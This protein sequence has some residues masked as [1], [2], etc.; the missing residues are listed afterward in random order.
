MTSRITVG[1]DVGGTFTDVFWFNA[2]ARAF[3]TCKVPSRRGDEAQGFLDG[4]QA[5]GGP[6]GIG[7][8]VHGTTVGTNTL[9]E[10]R[11]PKIGVI[12]TR[13][14][15]DVLEMRRRDRR[16]TW[17]LWGD[18][19]PIAARDMR[20]EVNERTLA[21][22]TIRTP[23]D[24]DGVRAAARQLLDQGAASL[25]IT[26]INAYANPE[27]EQRALE[28]VR[29]LWPNEHVG[30][31]HEV[32]AEIREFERSSTTALNAYLQP[33][34]GAYLGKL[35]EP[36]AQR[37]FKGQL[38]IVQSNGGIMAT[39]TARRL[40][41]RTALS[42]PAAGV[43]AGAALA[44]AAGFDNVITC[45]LGGTSFDVSVIAAGR[46]SIAA[47]STIDFGL[48]IRT[49]M[50][51][52]TTIGA[53]GGSIASV[54]PAGLLRV[55]PESAGS[56]PGPACY[57]QGNALPTL[58]DAQ[59]VLGRI[60]AARPLGGE[61]KSLDVDAASAAIAAQVG[62][63]LR[64]DVAD[65]A[66]AIVQVAE[67]RMAG[68]IRLVSIERGHDPTR[69]VAMAFGGGG[70]LHVGAL[71]R[72]VGLRGAVV[73]RFP[74]ITSA[75]G[76]VLADLRHDLVQTVNLDLA[77]LD[78]PALQA[79]LRE[80]G[81]AAS[82]VVA[83]AGMAI[84][85]I[86][87]LHELDMHYVGQTHTIAVPLNDAAEAGPISVTENRV[88]A[89][90]ETAYAASFSRLLHGIPVRVASLRVAAIGRR[91]PFDCAVF[92]PDADAS[93]ARA[94]QPSRAVWFP[95]GW[96]DTD[97]WSRLDL[98]AGAVIA[99]P[100]ILEQPDATTVIEPGLTG[101]VDALG[102]VLVASA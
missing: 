60:N 64:L 2:E 9:L 96:R 80:A 42:G 51:E 84:D 4:L 20:L 94:K 86:D 61:L 92:A 62:A 22:G 36:L 72:Q 99:G 53:G 14:F 77:G 97:V 12:T 10:R 79:R 24:L 65:A 35:Q 55:G 91:P 6:A 13:G 40:P 71:I 38:H 45:D 29:A 50:I 90:F 52:I 81:E 56:V 98:P 82:A 44:K 89:A 30:A 21:D 66:A 31:S 32:L 73:P 25:A 93:L 49:P 34:V 16:R 46:A 102:N 37:G 101:T 7:S 58:T 83:A 5:A 63:P 67:A 15:R 48:V 8:I 47:Q 27:N 95:G 3:R 74:G 100:A 41:V 59:V 39:P 70:A 69:F 88:R 26:F 68:A 23:V 75:L 33:V 28:A 18:F 85:R 54:D 1:V 57:G 19:V 78:A 17:G 87:V 76:C 11:G 43:V